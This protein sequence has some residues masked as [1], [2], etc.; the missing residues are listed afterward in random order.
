[1]LKRKQPN[2]LILGHKRHGK[3]TAAEILRDNYGLQFLSS[4]MVA[5]ENVMFDAFDNIG[6]YYSSVEECFEDR[7][8]HREVWFNTIF[9]PTQKPVNRNLNCTIGT[10]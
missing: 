10:N 6:V 7:V 2:I 8:T 1:M 4:S 5:A 3:D 9:L